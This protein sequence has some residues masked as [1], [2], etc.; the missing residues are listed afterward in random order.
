MAHL[1][2]FKAKA[3]V[4]A[5]DHH[6]LAIQTALHDTKVW[7]RI[8]EYG[9]CRGTGAIAPR[10]S[11]VASITKCFASISVTLSVAYAKNHMH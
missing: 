1:G 10:H 3:L 4:C 6:H 2:C 7:E 5:C 9:L 8:W 11:P